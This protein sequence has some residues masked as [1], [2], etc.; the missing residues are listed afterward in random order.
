VRIG[1]LLPNIIPDPLKIETSNS[2]KASLLPVAVHITLFNHK[3]IHSVQ[4]RD[5]CPTNTHKHTHTHTH[6]LAL[7]ALFDESAC[8]EL[9]SL[10]ALSCSLFNGLLAET[11][12]LRKLDRVSNVTPGIAGSSFV[13]VRFMRTVR[14]IISAQTFE[15]PHAVR[16]PDSQD[17][18]LS[19]NHVSPK[20]Y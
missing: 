3:E 4:S 10:W 8:I 17:E 12:S 9:T 16:L 11:I 18:R 2:S 6:T 1:L 13:F 14:F 15:L 5:Y 7:K 19:R 20:Y